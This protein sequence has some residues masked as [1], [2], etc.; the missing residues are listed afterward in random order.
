M[1]VQEGSILLYLNSQNSNKVLAIRHHE[2]HHSMSDFLFDS[3]KIMNLMMKSDLE[4]MNIYFNSFL[5]L[6]SMM[7]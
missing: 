1:N 3:V 7:N 5:E 2:V 4:E 6:F